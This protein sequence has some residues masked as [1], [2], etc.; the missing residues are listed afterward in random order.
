MIQKVQKNQIASRSTLQEPIEHEPMAA[1]RKARPL[2]MIALVWLA[3]GCIVGLALGFFGYLRQT[4]LY[5]STAQ[6]QILSADQSASAS[7]L[8]FD[9]SPVIVGR[10]NVAAAV[11]LSRLNQVAGLQEGVQ[12]PD[13]AQAV[14]LLMSNGRLDAKRIAASSQGGVYE[15]RFRGITPN[16]TRQVVDAIVDAYANSMPAVG[17][18]AAWDES[19]RLLGEARDEVAKRLDELNEQL[20]QIETPMDVAVRDGKIISEAD[21]RWQV[22]QTDLDDRHE[23]LAELSKRIVS[24]ERLVAQDATP[25][26]ILKQLEKPLSRRLQVL[27][28]SEVAGNPAVEPEQRQQELEARKQRVDQELL[29]LDTELT[30][31]LERYGASH[32]TVVAL[33][34]KIDS[35]KS[36][37]GVVED[38][39]TPLVSDS[40]QALRSG[41][42]GEQLAAVESLLDGLNRERQKREAEI[43]LLMR[44]LD[45]TAIRM[46]E[47]DRLL[48]RQESIHAQIKRQETL[49]S[50]IVARVEQLTGDSPFAARSLAV[51]A[52]AEAGHQ[53]A[54]LLMPNLVIGGTLGAFVGTAIGLLMM[55]GATLGNSDGV[56]MEKETKTEPDLVPRQSTVMT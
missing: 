29:P 16:S 21:T 38:E 6:I 45:E 20:E 3:F 47:Q 40:K 36:K 19:L 22:L 10:P 18:R 46:A 1:G 41:D 31:L 15:I 24:I 34:R 5:E 14:K 2:P 44:Q 11:K 39:L 28:S 53:V 12:D 48:R 42:E 25:E 32:P 27:T 37:F 4:P 17:D 7:E 35:V 23:A 51:L 33:K 8:L 56:A 55:L 49:E 52:P 13:E 54:P 26:M 30:R 43:E 9:E 50:E